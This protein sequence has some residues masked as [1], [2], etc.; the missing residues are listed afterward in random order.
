M[1]YLWSEKLHKVFEYSDED[2]FDMAK[3]QYP[4]E[5]EVTQEQAYLKLFERIARSMELKFGNYKNIDI[6]Q[7]CFYMLLKRYRL[8]GLFAP[9]KPWLDNSKMWWSFAKK[10]CLYIIREYKMVV[11]DLDIW[12]FDDNEDAGSTICCNNLSRNLMVEDTYSIEINDMCNDIKKAIDKLCLSKQYVDK[13]MG[14]FALCKLSKLSDEDTLTILEIKKP[15]LY[16]IRR[17]L[18]EYLNL[19]FGNVI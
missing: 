3:L 13:Q 19:R 5:V 17:A 16:E 7:E 10:S 1:Y 4:D 11:G 8:K 9:D 6:H 2:E 18:K 12:D 14:L 15:R